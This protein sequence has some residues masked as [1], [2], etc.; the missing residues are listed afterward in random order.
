MDRDLRLFAHFCVAGM[1]AMTTISELPIRL[2]DHDLEQTRR[3]RSMVYFGRRFPKSPGYYREAGKA[4]VAL[5]QDKTKHFWEGIVREV[6]GLGVSRA[7]ELMA[8]ARGKVTLDTARERTRARQRKLRKRKA[9]AN[10]PLP[11]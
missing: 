7:Y 3:V 10:E 5:R 4:L 6:C 11:K 8:I 1:S 9:Y 2:D